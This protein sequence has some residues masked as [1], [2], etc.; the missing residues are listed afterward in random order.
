VM[1]EKGAGIGFEIDEFLIKPVKPQDLLAALERIGL[2]TTA[3]RSIL[4]ID[5]DPSASKVMGP[6]LRASD[7]QMTAILDAESALAS[8][9]ASPPSAIVLDLMMP[10]M[11]GFEFLHRLRNTPKG[12]TTPVIVW[13]SKDLT[14]AERIRLQSSAFAI[15]RKGA[16]SA[17]LLLAELER[18]LPKRESHGR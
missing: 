11:D 7:Y 3:E 16:G 2:A 8:A 1:A 14:E 10:G 13:T 18:C 6:A 12:R 15:I 4:I 17:A 5:D 9:R